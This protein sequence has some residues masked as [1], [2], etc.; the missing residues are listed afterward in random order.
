MCE[1]V[2][3]PFLAACTQASG[4]G[5][6]SKI[7]TWRSENSLKNTACLLL[8]FCLNKEKQQHLWLITD[9]FCSNLLILEP[10]RSESAILK[11]RVSMSLYSN[12]GAGSVV[13]LP[14]RN[15]SFLNRWVHLLLSSF[16]HVQ[17]IEL[18]C[19]SKIEF[20]Q[21]LIPDLWIVV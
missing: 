19:P 1:V 4:T 3:W 2:E 16:S 15:T 9:G 13:L 8:S 6:G 7:L 17:S 5:S 20:S 14:I 11:N 10:W 21:F 18:N 12:S